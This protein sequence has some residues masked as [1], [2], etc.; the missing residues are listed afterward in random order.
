MTDTTSREDCMVI[1]V[2]GEHFASIGENESV[3]IC[4][5]KNDIGFINLIGN[6]F[7]E[8]LCRKLCRPIK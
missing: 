8:S 1:N 3:E 4:R 2:D 7:H 6:S 5:G